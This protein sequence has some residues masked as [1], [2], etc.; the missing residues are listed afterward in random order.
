MI[1]SLDRVPHRSRLHREGWVISARREPP[2]ARLRNLF[3]LISHAVDFR[4][5]ACAAAVDPGRR[6]SRFRGGQ[7]D[8]PPDSLGFASNVP[9]CRCRAITW[10]LWR[11]A[12][13]VIWARNCQCQRWPRRYSAISAAICQ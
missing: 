2:F 9:A 4:T 5:R 6:D 11:M 7:F 10:I 13:A 3:A 12:S 8:G 1:S